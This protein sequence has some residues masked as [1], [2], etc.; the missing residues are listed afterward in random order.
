M[1]VDKRLAGRCLGYALIAASVVSLLTGTTYE[2]ASDHPDRHWKTDSPRNGHFV[3]RADDP[4]TFWLLVVA[5]AGVGSVLVYK[6]REGAE[7]E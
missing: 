5:G 4:G 3:K 6:T 2:P 1:N 7:D